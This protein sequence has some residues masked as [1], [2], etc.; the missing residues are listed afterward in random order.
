MFRTETKHTGVTATVLTRI[1][2]AL[3][4]NLE[5]LIEVFRDISVPAWK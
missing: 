1:P 4:S 3:D 5:I 2:E